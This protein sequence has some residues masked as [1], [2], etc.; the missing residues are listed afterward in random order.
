MFVEK[1]AFRIS[2]GYLYNYGQGI[3]LLGNYVVIS[4]PGK[5]EIYFYDINSYAKVHTLKSSDLM[6]AKTGLKSVIGSKLVSFSKT[7]NNVS[8]D[9]LLIVSKLSSKFVVD[10]FSLDASNAPVRVVSTAGDWSTN[11]DGEEV[12]SPIQADVIKADANYI[13]VASETGDGLA[14]V[15]STSDW[16]AE[17]FDAKLQQEFG[18]GMRANDFTYDN[19]HFY[20]ASQTDEGGEGK[21]YVSR[22]D[23][24]S[25][26]RKTIRPL[27]GLRSTTQE[28]GGSLEISGR[29]LY[30][31][32]PYYSE[33][34]ATLKGRLLYVDLDL[35]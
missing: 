30:V 1:A 11:R 23:G 28:F 13:F 4:A 8:K 32:A 21:L 24:V 26:T 6:E 31:G 27:S 33:Q 14:K 15:F 5:E 10:T 25:Q 22:I 18:S 29:R 34:G 20:V 16:L 9:Y 2:N 3:A 12:F 35:P 19:T 7:V 17:K